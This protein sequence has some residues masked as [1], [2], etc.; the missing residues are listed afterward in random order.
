MS[1]NATPHKSASYDDDVRQTIPFYEEMHR[2]ALDLAL[3]LKPDATSW[4]DTGCGTGFLV[5]GA[6]RL[7]PSAT[8]TL[9]DPARPML[10]HARQRLEGLPSGRVAEY[11]EVASPELAGPLAGRR[12]EIITAMQ[13]HHY[14]RRPDRERALAVCHQLLHPGGLLIVFE[15]TDPATPE[16][17]A[18]G[19]E[20]WCRWQ[21]AQGKPAEAVAEHRRRHQ[22]KYFPITAREHL[23]A[24]G[25]AGFRMA[26]QM[27]FSFMQAGFYAIK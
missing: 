14:M 13:C 19:L 23:E 7:F 22:V 2:Q 21:L 9:A 5:E 24:L 11:L 3:S 27:W 25:R 8:F 12:F 1:D 18:T 6:A 4:L 16:G 17:V 15:N 20:R 26:E 10:E